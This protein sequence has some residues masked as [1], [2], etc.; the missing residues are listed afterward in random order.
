MTVGRMGGQ[1]RGWGEELGL[2]GPAQKALRGEIEEKMYSEA[3]IQM[4][5]TMLRCS[6]ALVR[7][8]SMAAGALAGTGLGQRLG[9]LLQVVTSPVLVQ[10]L[11]R[12]SVCQRRQKQLQDT[13][14]PPEQTP[15]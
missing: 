12:S 6:Q 13:A 9:L 10:H 14:T 7:A 11:S 15:R 3:Q 2:S 8:A 1:Q 5:R 4:T